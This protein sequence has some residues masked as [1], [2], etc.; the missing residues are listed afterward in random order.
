VVCMGKSMQAADAA[1]LGRLLARCQVGD[2]SPLA[3]GSLL[4]IRGT[5][6]G[7]GSDS[8]NGSRNDDMNQFLQWTATTLLGRLRCASSRLGRVVQELRG[9]NQ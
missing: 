9:M 8:R 5:L 3:T 1:D 4:G 7:S 2:T 6:C